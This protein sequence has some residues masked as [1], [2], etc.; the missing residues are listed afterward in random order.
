MDGDAE[1]QGSAVL[2][3]TSP[4]GEGQP[5]KVLLLRIFIT[6]IADTDLTQEHPLGE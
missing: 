2:C 4:T 6:R 3:L 1:E 5:A